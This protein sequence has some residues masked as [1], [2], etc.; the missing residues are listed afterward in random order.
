[1][2]HLYKDHYNNMVAEGGGFPLIT[3]GVGDS[4][5]K[6]FMEDDCIT[7]GSGKFNFDRD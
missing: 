1:M 3:R 6:E 7:S 5:L 2:D 4:T